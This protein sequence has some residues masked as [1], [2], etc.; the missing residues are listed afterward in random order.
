M[1]NI[2]TVDNF[3]VY[4]FAPEIYVPKCGIRQSLS[5]LCKSPTLPL[6]P[7]QTNQI[8]SRCTRHKMPRHNHFILQCLL[9]LCL[10]FTCLD[11]R[12]RGQS[13][14]T[15]EDSKAEERHFDFKAAPGEEAAEEVEEKPKIVLASKGDSGS[16]VAT[17]VAPKVEVEEEATTQSTEDC[18]FLR[19]YR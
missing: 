17:T 9:L 6:N 3:F 7:H 1:L 16:T 11:S 15:F 5:N 2:I 8:N 10:L 18:E 19:P 14:R 4:P 13:G 12:R